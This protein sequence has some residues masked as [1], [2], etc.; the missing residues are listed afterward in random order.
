MGPQ[1]MSST[2]VHIDSGKWLKLTDWNTH[3]RV[4]KNTQ[5]VTHY[6]YSP[7]L[8]LF[9]PNSFFS[10]I[11]IQLLLYSL[12]SLAL[13]HP[14]LLCLCFYHFLLH[15]FYLSVLPLALIPRTLLCLFLLS[16]AAFLYIC[17]PS[18]LHLHCVL[19]YYRYKGAYLCV[20]AHGEVCRL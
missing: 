11:S 8:S 14:S 5:K 2:Q 4:H 13:I 15:S 17:P 6:S 10:L 16:S 18:L 12:L 9:P 7:F 20:C 19:I 3:N 1:F